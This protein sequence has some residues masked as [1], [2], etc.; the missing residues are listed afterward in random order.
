MITVYLNNKLAAK[1]AK[2]INWA[3]DS[4]IR[5]YSAPLKVSVFGEFGLK[6]LKTSLVKKGDDRYNKRQQSAEPNAITV[7]AILLLGFWIALLRSNPQ[8]TLEYI[9]FIKVFSIRSS[10]EG[11]TVMR[12]TSANNIFYYVF[13]SLVTA[14][15]LYLIT[16]FNPSLAV[17]VSEAPAYLNIFLFAL[18]VF[19]FLFVELALLIFATSIFGL[20]DFAPGQFYNL[21]RCLLGGF[22][23]ALIFLLIIFMIG[24]GWQ[25]WVTS[26]RFFLL[27]LFLIYISTTFLKLIAKGGFTVLHLFSYLCVSEIIPLL[28]VIKIFFF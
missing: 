6:H 3:V 18:Y 15:G 14:I 4:L 1:G 27:G 25:L 24:S 10:E 20:S 22:G 12:I 2:E 11:S 28:I 5:I 21:I 13:C 23:F 26:I 7:V 17:G 16:D 19:L 9:N 8:A